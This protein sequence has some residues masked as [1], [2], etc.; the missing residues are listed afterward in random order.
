MAADPHTDRLTHPMCFLRADPT[1]PT[2]LSFSGL[3]GLTHALLP[4]KPLTQLGPLPSRPQK[5]PDRRRN[6]TEAPAGVSILKKIHVVK[7]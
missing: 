1:V 4:G 3:P 2:A 5:G 7:N 6:L